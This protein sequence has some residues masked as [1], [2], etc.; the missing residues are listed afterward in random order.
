M[1]QVIQSYRTGILK[2]DEVPQPVLRPGGVLVGNRF[3]LISAGTER[4]TVSTAQ[5]SLIGKAMERPEMV[6]KVMKAARKEGWADTLRMV[7]DR[8]DMPAALGYSCAGV[9]LEV[10]ERVSEF[11]VG[12]RV[13]CA[14][15]NF[16]SHAESVYVP[17]NLAVKIPAGVDF[18]EASFVALG[19]IALQG[20]RQAEV[21]LGDKVAVIGL[22]L[23]GQLS[24]QLLKA[25]GCLVIASDPEEPKCQLAQ[26]LGADRSVIPEQLE[27]ATAELTSGKGVDAVLL[28]ASTKENGP[29]EKAAQISRRRGRVV[30]VGAVGMTI[31]RE[32]YYRKELELRL[33]TSYGPG[34]YDSDYE[35]RGIDYP[36]GYVRWTENR[37]M[38]AFLILVQQKRV[39]LRPLVTHTY[40]IQEAEKAYC[41]LAEGDE[42][43]LGILLA[44]PAENPPLR[45]PRITVIPNRSLS[46]VNLAILGSGNHVKDRLLPC[47]LKMK[48]VAIRAIC[49][50]TGAG[51]KVLAEKIQAAYCTSD[52][53]EVLK[54]PDVNA[55]L[56]G[57]RHDMHA[58]LVMDAL[59]AGKHVFV[60][61]PLC[62]TEEELESILSVYS[63][64]AEEG[65][66]LTVGF[67]RRFSPHIVRARE[68][69]HDR[70][71]PLVMSYRVNCGPIPAGHW[72]Q[73][74]TVGGGR[75]VGE[76]C[77]F[78]DTLQAL[79]GA[80]PVSLHARRIGEHASGMTDDQAI[81]SFSFADGSIGTILYAAG[82]D[83]A[84]AKERIEAFGDG[85]SWVLDDFRISEYFAHGKRKQFKT[86]KTDKGFQSEMDRFVRSI[87]SGEAPPIPVEEMAAVT[88]A[89]LLA[90]KSQKTGE[91]Y[92]V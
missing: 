69:F 58:V 15:Q 25:S 13:A 46:R 11:A 2:V 44:Y 60:E 6:Q 37:N 62:L 92:D 3:S 50:G 90:V 85:K 74:P 34:R 33:S 14:G 61:K 51:S 35:E 12:D 77:H 71:N 78:V 43:Y 76:V 73:D 18:D 28:T 81:F 39:D 23:L 7:F 27:E 26:R 22:G 56:I 48:D 8:L 10:G 89:C 68:F 57:T 67:N 83:T 59:N 70:R 54:D 32:P 16:A 45:N 19:A 41:L 42:P 36:Y 31:P 4:S 55:V 24:V 29:I 53:R 52:Y 64:K 84:L 87:V 40:P 38:Q 75:I 65:F 91:L 72:I 1:K 21:G 80:S 17:K 63:K 47:L 82:G 88:R 66:C 20:I 5:K 9:V 30:V 86:G 49:S 79:C